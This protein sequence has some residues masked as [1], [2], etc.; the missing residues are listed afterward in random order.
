MT[1]LRVSSVCLGKMQCMQVHMKMYE[2]VRL[3]RTYYK[4][5][6]FLPPCCLLDP[7]MAIVNTEFRVS[8]TRK[9]LS[10]YT[11]IIHTKVMGRASEASQ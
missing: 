8:A 1:T 9:A 3:L 11:L 7:Y 4:N 5:N 2:C 10:K 6:K